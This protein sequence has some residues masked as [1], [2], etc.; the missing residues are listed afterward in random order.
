M[1]TPFWTTEAIRTYYEQNT[2]L[3]LSFV[4]VSPTYTIHRSL[5]P[6]GVAGLDE[7]LQTSNRLIRAEIEQMAADQALSELTILDLGCGVGGYALLPAAAAHIADTGAG[8]YAQPAAG[9]RGA[10][11]GA[12]SVPLGGMHV[13]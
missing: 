3:F 1:N 7:A 13:C 10:D 11:A 12:P 5:W 4:G 8:H 6:D 2:Q 9:T